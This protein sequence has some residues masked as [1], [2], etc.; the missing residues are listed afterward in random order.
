MPLVL[1]QQ[2]LRVFKPPAFALT[3]VLTLTIG[4]GANLAVFRVLH[5]VLFAK[6]PIGEPGQLYSL[7]AVRSPFDAQWFF[8]FPAYQRLRQDSGASVIARSGLGS[9]VLQL[10]NGFSQ[11]TS[12]QLVSDNFFAVLGLSPSA[13]RLFQPAD[14]TPGQSELPVVL[15]YGFAKEHFAGAQSIV[16]LKAVLNRI[17]IVVV[18]IAPERFSGV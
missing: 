7:H 16:G 18:G 3:V 15:R 2:F 17:P 4:I 8:S 6:L 14:D 10:R 5:G 1:R 9:G 11:E 12:F 13:G